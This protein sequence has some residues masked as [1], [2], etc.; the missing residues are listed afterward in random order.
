MAGTK[1]GSRKAV[2]KTKEVYG[3]DFYADIG[4]KGAGRRHS[5]QY[6]G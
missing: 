1:E 2:A 5:A 3:E 4:K 6:L